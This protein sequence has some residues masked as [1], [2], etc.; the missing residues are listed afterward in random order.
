M[1]NKYQKLASESVFNGLVF[2]V[3]RDHVKLPSGKEMKRDTLLH[4]GAVVVLP[5]LDA[6]RLVLVRQYRHSIGREILEFPAGTLEKGEDPKNCVQRELREEIGFGAE[7]I[8]SL[9]TNLPAP[10]FCNELQHFFYATELFAEK[11]AGDDD[12]IIEVEYL[13]ISEIENLISAGDFLDGKSMAIFLKA[14]L[15]GLI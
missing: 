3:I 5:R 9:G 11:L 13:S 6:N 10:G 4:P 7:K 2:E 14:R 15:L 12:E 8:Q 1:V